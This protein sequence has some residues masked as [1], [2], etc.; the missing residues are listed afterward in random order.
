MPKTVEGMQDA[1]RSGGKDK[2]VQYCQD[3]KRELEQESKLLQEKYKK[4]EIDLKLFNQKRFG[5]NQRTA[6]LNGCVAAMNKKFG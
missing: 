6:D 5:L 3:W 4:G 1:L 2:A